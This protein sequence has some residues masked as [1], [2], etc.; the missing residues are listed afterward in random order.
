MRIFEKRNKRRI[1]LNKIL[2]LILDGK[3][4]YGKKTISFHWIN[5]KVRFEGYKMELVQRKDKK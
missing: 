4:Q 5:L 3:V 1:D 2:L